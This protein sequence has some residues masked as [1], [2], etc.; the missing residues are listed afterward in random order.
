M[1]STFVL[2]V[3]GTGITTPLTTNLVY[4]EGFLIGNINVPAGPGRLFVIRAYDSE[5]LLIYSGRSVADVVGGE[6]LELDIEMVPDVPMIK[7]SPIYIETLQGD[8][9][10][11]K[12]SVFNLPDIGRIRMEVSNERGEYFNF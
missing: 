7:L 5:G 3:T 6:E 10:A 4:H 2:T 9:L 8:L 11:M 12:I 1:A